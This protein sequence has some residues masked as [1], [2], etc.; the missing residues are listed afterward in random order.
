MTDCVLLVDKGYLFSEI[1]IDLFETVNIRLETPGRTNQK[2]AKPYPFIFEKSRRRIETLFSQLCGQL[3]IRRNY[4]KSFNGFKNR[5][6]AKITALTTIQ[7]L[8]RFVFDRKLN[9]IKTNP[10]G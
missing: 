2:N 8:N 1:Q 6:L 9:N 4:P 3:T 7:Y 10:M 5:I